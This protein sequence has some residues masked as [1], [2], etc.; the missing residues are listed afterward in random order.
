MKYHPLVFVVGATGVGKSQWA[1]ESAQKTGGVILNCDSLQT[2]QEL[3]IGTAKPSMELRAALPHF[4]FD[5][6]PPGN[7]LTAGDFRR[8][9]LSILESELPKHPVF[10]VGGSGFY[11]QAL[12]K[13]MFEIDKVDPQIEESVRA[14]FERL[15]SEKFFTELQKMDPETAAILNPNDSYRVQRAMVVFRG[16]GKKLS[17]LKKQFKQQTLPYAL[18]K[19]GL[20]QSR[21]RL[22]SKIILR[23]QQMLQDGFIDEVRGLIAKGFGSWSMLQSVGYKQIQMFLNGELT[24]AQL[25]DEIVLRT[26]QLA[27]R[28]MT[29]FQRDKE[30]N[31]FNIDDAKKAQDWLIHELDMVS[32]RNE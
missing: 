13:G 31:W 3:D 24:E 7:V 12:E 6:I 20:R 10:A 2:Y 11:I 16:H 5:I 14:E 27:K 28:Q 30:I 15:G 17:D 18:I 21:E 4:L 25:P 23:T 26:M 8:T 9:A 19:V 29:W 32:H 22:R 1:F